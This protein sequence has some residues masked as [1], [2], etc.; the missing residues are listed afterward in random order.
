LPLA[1]KVEA[2]GFE[3]TSPGV[4]VLLAFGVAFDPVVTYKPTVA[5]HRF[6][7]APRC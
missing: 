2:V 3:P 6:Q 7:F 1:Q 5:P 4:P